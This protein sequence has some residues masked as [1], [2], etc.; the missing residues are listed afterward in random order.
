MGNI[1]SR[2]HLCVNALATN[3]NQKGAK[4]KLVNLLSAID[5]D[6]LR[7]KT[8]LE[9]TEDESKLPR[10]GPLADV[11]CATACWRNYLT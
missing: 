9:Q 4:D 10:A 3:G 1:I 5:P 8:K 6:S 11:R 2:R 7:G